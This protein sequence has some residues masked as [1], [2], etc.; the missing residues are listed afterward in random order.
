M[1]KTKIAICH[2]RVGGTDGVSLE[3]EK[4]EQILKEHGFNV[5]LIAGPRSKGADYVI[6]ELEWDDGVVPIVKENGFIHFRRWDLEDIEIKRKIRKLSNA[7]EKELTRIQRKEK[8]D[9]VL[10][11]NIFSFGGHIAAARGFLN[12]IEKFKLKTIAT[13]H[14][15]FWERREFHLPRNSY[16]KKYIDKYMPPKSEYIK[17]VVI[18]SITQHELKKRSGIRA[19]ILPDTFDFEQ[20]EWRK[21]KFN[22]DFLKQFDI[23]QN[24]LVI[25]QATRII[26][27]KGIETAIDFANVLQENISKLR[28]KKLYN[29]KKLNSRS[30]VIL[31]MAGYT[32]DEKRDYLFKLKT[33]AFDE[34]V[35]V[36]FVSEHIKAERHYNGGVKTLSLWDAYVYA[37]LI[38]FPSIWEGWGN[39]LIEAV[40]A[41]KPFV[42]FE[43]P[44]FKKD[45]VKEKYNLISLGDKIRKNDK[46]GL[47][48]IPQ[49]NMDK[50][51]RK[52]IKWLTDKNLNKKLEKNFGIGKKYHG[53]KV[54]EDFLFK[55][56][57]IK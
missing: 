57:G 43:Y 39:Q 53:Y 41:K 45:I 20:K 3:I 25:L 54:I 35:R 36:R 8:F 14:D 49:K 12:W 32:E 9:L 16:L 6:K 22:K 47:Y 42:I 1:P 11:H 50:A 38:T 13:H 44:V 10:I 21:D 4:R 56:M 18:N 48:Q 2:Y 46:T 17:H 28:G 15:F 5:K 55:K 33:K 27:R 23:G 52:T 51:V 29:G 31:I 34:R 40:F 7:I 19:E 24:D 30:N 26:P 37:D